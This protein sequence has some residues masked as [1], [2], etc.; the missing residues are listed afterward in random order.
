M[1]GTVDHLPVALLL[2]IKLQVSHTDLFFPDLDSDNSSLIIN[3]SFIF[4]SIAEAKILHRGAIEN[5]FHLQL[6]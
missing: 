3:M 2:Q 1:S 6:K 5:L 4:I